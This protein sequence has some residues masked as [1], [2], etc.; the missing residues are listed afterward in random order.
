MHFELKNFKRNSL[1]P[2]EFAGRNFKPDPRAE[3]PFAKSLSLHD[4]WINQEEVS[5]VLIVPTVKK[6]RMRLK[7]KSRQKNRRMVKNVGRTKRRMVN[8]DERT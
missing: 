3:N 1:A 2:Q 4:H 7:A 8:N 6:S 5:N